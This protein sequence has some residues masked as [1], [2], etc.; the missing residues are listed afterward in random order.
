VQQVVGLIR[1]LRAAVATGLGER[2][3]DSLAALTD[4][5]DRE[6]TALDA[7]PHELHTLNRRDPRPPTSGRIE[8]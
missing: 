2:T 4:D 5:L 1:E 3:D 7:G 6:I 8:S